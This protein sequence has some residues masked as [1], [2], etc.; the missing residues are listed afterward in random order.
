MTETD[1]KVV[2]GSLRDS[3]R[4]LRDIASGFYNDGGG[5]I[6]KSTT[7]PVSGLDVG[8][9]CADVGDALQ[10]RAQALGSGVDTLGG[11]FT[12]AAALYERGDSAAAEGI[13]FDPPEPAEER[14]GDDPGEPGY[15]PVSTYERALQDAGLLNGTSGGFY[16]EW[17]RNAAD[18]GV[19]PQVIVDIARRFTITPQS[20]DVLKGMERVVDDNGT[21]DPADDKDYFLLPENVTP[22]Q[23]R[24]AAL[25]TYIVNAGTGYGKSGPTDFAE[26]PYTANEVQ[27]IID[28]QARNAWSY[29]RIPGLT[30]G[31]GRFAVTPNGMMMGVGGDP[32]QQ[33][34]SQQGGSTYGDLFAM[35]VDDPGDANQRLRDIISSGV[36]QYQSEDGTMRKA[37]DLDLVLHHEE[38]HSQQWADMGPVEFAKAYAVGLGYDQIPGKDNPFEVNAGYGDGGYR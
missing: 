33:T 15:D 5:P 30:D 29:E 9:A 4:E 31:G 37:M 20:F 17:L 12:D 24:Q 11:K 8:A 38:R 28:R 16:R 2:T 21:D 36:S 14:I 6:L 13:Q 22:E 25:M 23:A 27:R 34:M 19:P 18:N 10:A 26:T 7:R 35:N 1:L 32:V 3:A